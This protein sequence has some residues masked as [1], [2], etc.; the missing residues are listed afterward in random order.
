[1]VDGTALGNADILG[2][3]LG[4]FQWHRSLEQRAL[5]RQQVFLGQVC[6]PRGISLDA[7]GSVRR[8]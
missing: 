4:T 5:Q 3:F 7:F 2:D 6:G 1:M 8:K